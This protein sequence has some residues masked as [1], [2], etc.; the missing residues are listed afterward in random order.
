MRAASCKENK[1]ETFLFDTARA[2]ICDCRDMVAALKQ[3]PNNII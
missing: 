2:A 1:K 3:T